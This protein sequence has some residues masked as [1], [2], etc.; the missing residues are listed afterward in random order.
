M[1]PFVQKQYDEYQ[2]NYVEQ[3][4]LS[5]EELRELIIKDLS[6]VSQMGVEEYTLYQKWLEIQMKYPTQEVSTLFGVEQQ[7]VK[8]EHNQ[9]ITESKNNI[10][11]PEDPM[12]FEKLEP[13]LV[14]T[15]SI[16]DNQS[17]G[18]LMEKWN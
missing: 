2:A 12:D 8:P 3:D 7:L 6:Q 16:K 4:V 15:D 10:W 1:E 5:K 11:F 13:E 14:Y 9:L 18:T 17:A